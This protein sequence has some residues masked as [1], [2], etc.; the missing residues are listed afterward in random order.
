MSVAHTEG[1]YYV[2][3]W[4]TDIELIETC[5]AQFYLWGICWL[6]TML[7]F[8]RFR[9]FLSFCGAPL[10]CS[11]LG[12]SLQAAISENAKSGNHFQEPKLKDILLQISLGLKYIHNYGMVHMD[13]KP[14]QYGS[15]RLL[16]LYFVLFPLL[17]ESVPVCLSSVKGALCWKNPFHQFPFSPPLPKFQFNSFNH[18]DPGPKGQGEKRFPECEA[19]VWKLSI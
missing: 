15:P 13:I 4:H 14:S 1:R 10:C 6:F 3:H 12:G 16:W 11:F 18:L 8:I 2:S 9:P 17:S 7:S 19:Q 5:W